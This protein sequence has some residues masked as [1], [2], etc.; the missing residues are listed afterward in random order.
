MRHEKHA[1][2]PDVPEIEIEE[3]ALDERRGMQPRALLNIVTA[4]AVVGVLAVT[5]A[6][7]FSRLFPP[8]PFHGQNVYVD[9]GDR[10]EALDA[11]TG[12]VRWTASQGNELIAVSAGLLVGVQTI[13]GT[14]VF[15]LDAMSGVV[16][17]QIQ[18]SNAIPCVPED[19]TVVDG[20]A[21]VV[22][23]A[24]DIQGAIQGA[25]QG[26]RATSAKQDRP[27]ALAA[28]VAIDLA[29]GGVRWRFQS[30]QAAALTVGAAGN[31][32]LIGEQTAENNPSLWL[33]ALDA[34]TGVAQ[35]RGSAGGP[36][37]SLGY[38]S[39]SGTVLAQSNTDLYSFAVQD[40]TM[41]WHH[42]FVLYTSPL[43]SQGMAFITTFANN[44]SQNGVT[45]VLD[46][47]TGAVRW[48][49]PTSPIIEVNG[50]LVTPAGYLFIDA[51]NTTPGAAAVLLDPRDGAQEWQT[52]VP[53]GTTIASVVPGS[54][55]LNDGAS[56]T[57]L[58]N[59]QGTVRWRLT[60]PATLASVS[61]TT[62]LTA[63]NAVVIAGGTSIMAADG[64]TGK[65]R[66]HVTLPTTL[67]LPPLVGN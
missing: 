9:F 2:L 59:Q 28:V 38:D 51:L 30:H 3:A 23:V 53:Y 10:I 34:R 18:L 19:L 36:I 1:G 31:D 64:T 56:F 62:T 35:W 20:L 5:V 48:R 45:L 63:N 33:Y 25:M 32:V 27:V 16:R 52:P 26:A 8:P 41:L 42:S 7:N 55:L 67:T 54:I 13:Q 57:A 49:V 15:A 24:S 46:L 29:H 65:P 21:L 12:R 60:L 39:A 61:A 17:W 6:A 66:W 14:S 22:C 4:L 11:R 44:Q 50:A 43:V 40:G 37:L 47:R 58:D